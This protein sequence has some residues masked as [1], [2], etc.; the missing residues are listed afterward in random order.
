MPVGR[1]PKK[2][3]WLTEVRNAYTGELMPLSV[4]APGNEGEAVEAS[5]YTG[6]FKMG[7]GRLV[8]FFSGMTLK[9]V[10]W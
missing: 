8:G 6:V 2:K 1:L 4:V 10:K 9:G 7:D 5:W 3:L